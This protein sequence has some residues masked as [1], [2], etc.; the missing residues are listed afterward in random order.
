MKLTASQ[1]I[2][3]RLAHE[4]RRV[5][6]DWRAL[7][8]LRRATF[9]IPPRERRWSRLPEHPQEL[10]PLLRQMVE[11]GELSPIKR[12]RQLYEVTVPYARLGFLE[13]NEVLFEVNPYAVVSHFSAL[14]FHGL[15]EAFPNQMTVTISDDV[16]GGL[17]PLDSAPE[18]WEGVQL[19][20][21]RTPAKVLEIPIRWIRVK[22]E[23]FFGSSEYQPHGVRIR[24]TSRERTLLDGL[25]DPG[26]SGGILNVLIAWALARDTMNLDILV[27]QVNRFGSAVLRQRVGFILDELGLGHPEVEKW[28][29]S[30][31]RG[32]SSRLFASEPYSSVYSER[33]NLSLNGPIALLHEHA[34]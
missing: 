23:R 34:A 12:V 6:S 13:E 22:P 1:A 10:A 24:V 27:N 28:S 31:N 32:G 29:E 14:F 5:L 30:P 11:R 19:P 26:L 18:D 16:T 2:L 33:W 15:T 21:G 7:I 8:L 20:R 3:E 17:L 9:E 4:R 25:Q